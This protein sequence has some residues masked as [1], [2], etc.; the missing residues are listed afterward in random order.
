M[1]VFLANIDHLESVAVLFNRYRIFYNQASNLEAAKEFL[2]ERFQ[3]HDSVIFAANNNGELVGF[4]QLYPSF[5]SVSMQRIWIL[6]DLYV[7]ESYRRRGIAKLLM[8]TAEE[9]AK[10]NGAIRVI[11]ATQITNTTAQK[12]Y[13]TRD[14]IKNEDFYHYALQLQ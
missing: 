14:Y 8:N 3:N 9:Y 2:K 6:N 7:E 4:T 11:L 12:L 13:E 5:S 1:E 10:K